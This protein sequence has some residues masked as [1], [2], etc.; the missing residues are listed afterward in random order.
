MRL[1]SFRSVAFGLALGLM[2]GSLSVW[3]QWA[4][5]SIPL[6]PGWNAVFL[7]VTPGQPYAD[8]LFAAMPQV[9]SVWQFNRRGASVE[10]TEAPGTVLQKTEHWRVWFPRSD[11]TYFLRTLQ[12]LDGGRAYLIKVSDQAGPFVWSVKGL[13]VWQQTEILANSL[14]LMGLPARSEPRPTFLDFLKDT[15]EIAF[16]PGAGSG[17]YAIRPDGREEQIRQTTRAQIEPGTAYWVRCGALVRQLVPLEITGQTT[18]AG[19]LDFGTDQRELSLVFRNLSSTQQLS[20]R[21]AVRASEPAPPGF[22][23]V[24]GDVPL[25]YLRQQPASNQFEW[26]PLTGTWT[27]TL[28]TNEQREVRLAVRRSLLAK[29]QTRGNA[30]AAYQSLLEVEEDPH[31]WRALIPVVAESATAAR[32]LHGG[33]GLASI[34]ANLPT[35]SPHQGLW[36]GQVWI[37]RASR[38]TLP[39]VNSVDEGPDKETPASAADPKTSDPRPPAEIPLATLPVASPLSCR[40]LVHVDETNQPRLL[41]RVLLA[42]PQTGTNQQ[43]GLYQSEDRVPAGAK[44][45]SRISSIA[46]PVMNP[47]KMAGQ[48]SEA[49][50]ARVNL[51]YDDPVNP[52]K[53]AYHPDHD[54]L[55]EDFSTN[56][57]AAGRE[58]FTVERSVSFN[59]KVTYETDSGTFLPPGPVMA[60][61]GTNQYVTLPALTFEGDFTLEAWV[62]IAAAVTDDMPLFDLGNGPNADHVSLKLEAGS[63]L[64]I[65]SVVRNGQVSRLASQHPFPV[66]QWVHVAAVND[67]NGPSR[68]YWNAKVEAEGNLDPAPGGTRTRNYFGRGQAD[69][70]VCFRGRGYDLVVGGDARSAA[71][72]YEDMYLSASD[73]EN[74]LLAY[75]PANEGLGTTLRDVGDA[76]QPA[77]LQGATWD[78]SELPPIPFWGIG[79]VEGTY[80]EV[81]RGLRPYPIVLEGP[82]QL[83]RV[84]RNPV[85]Q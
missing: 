75:W 23:E 59:F 32:R 39:P 80:R 58:S 84:N 25:A 17:I 34:D 57:L 7:Q 22:P 3:A 64:M 78:S 20:L 62:R 49:M 21:L 60:F 76:H 26:V 67:T 10:F 50:A 68:I 66:A 81:I 44:V 77:T 72:V 85:L 41:Q 42:T 31:G 56:R 12:R 37:E 61:S 38:S 1:R 83:E 69:P 18:A 24:A 40:L 52:F 35:Y 47:V 53:H 16:G 14:N 15:P 46:F 71:G 51:D 74:E 11:P 45:V 9:Q 36:I 65:F 19:L 2:A 82:F 6:Q 79:R 73:I 43:V 30:G 54:N 5:Q 29:Y 8:D 33:A 28:A 27:I 55:D 63:G 13:P 4:Q 70:P 48:F